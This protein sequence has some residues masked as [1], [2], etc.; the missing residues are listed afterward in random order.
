MDLTQKTPATTD[1]NYLK[2]EDQ[3]LIEPIGTLKSVITSIMGILTRFNF[4]V[5]NSVEG[6]P[7]YTAL[8]RNTLGSEHESHDIFRKR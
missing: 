1:K 7:S 3:I 4:E 8:N 5:I 6:I 2:V